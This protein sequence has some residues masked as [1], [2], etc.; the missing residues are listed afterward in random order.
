MVISTLPSA[1]VLLLLPQAAIPTQVA[2]ARAAAA[3]DLNFIIVS[4]F[5]LIGITANQRL[6]KVSKA[7]HRNSAFC[8]CDKDSEP[9]DLHVKSDLVRFFNFIENS[10]RIF[11][12]LIINL[13]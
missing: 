9:A 12:G 4:L 5:I 11:D 6:T 3:T 10:L 1:L 13:F 7:I 2:M 8:C